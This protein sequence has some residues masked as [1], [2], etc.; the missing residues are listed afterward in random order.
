LGPSKGID[1]LGPN[2][3]ANRTSIAEL[4]G[5]VKVTV[6]LI[7]YTAVMVSTNIDVLHLICDIA[8]GA[9]YDN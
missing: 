3:K 8:T 9:I 1:G 7:V 6:P 4:L 2:Q 5:V